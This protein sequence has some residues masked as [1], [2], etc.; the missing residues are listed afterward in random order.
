MYEPKVLVTGGAGYVGSTLVPYMIREKN[1]RV[2]VL[3]DFRWGQHPFFQVFGDPDRA[4][5]LEVVRGDVCDTEALKRAA[6]GCDGVIHLAG[7]VGAPAC[8]RFPEESRRVNVDGTKAVAALGIPTVNASSGSVYGKVEGTCVEESPTGPLS[9]YGIHK[10]EA[11]QILDDEMLACHLRFATGYG[12]APRMRMDV[13]P[14]DFAW[15]AIQNE[16]LKVYQ[17]DAR[18]TF[19][20]VFDMARAFAWA[21]ERLW[22]AWNDQAEGIVLNAGHEDGNVSKGGLVQMLLQHVPELRWDLTE[23]ADPD[24]RDYAVD[25]SKIRAQGWAPEWG[26]A[27]GIAQLVRALKAAPKP[28]PF[29]NQGVMG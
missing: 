26:F 5:Q 10:L 14:N 20:H 21:M 4:P 17:A 15:Q 13:L 27:E 3:D 18:R 22:G 6:D 24:Q 28:V 19:I 8:A 2:V 25:Y 23:G 16:Y 7:V 11:E 12:T 29:T 9:L 1:W